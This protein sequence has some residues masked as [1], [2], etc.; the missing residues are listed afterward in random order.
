M[1]TKP[2]SNT[3]T[4]RLVLVATV[5]ALAVLALLLITQNNSVHVIVREPIS[6]N[7]TYPGTCVSILLLRITA[8]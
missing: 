7:S 2:C 8:C 1:L 3:A 4:S 5:V 6:Y